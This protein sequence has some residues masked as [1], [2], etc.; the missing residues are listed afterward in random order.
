MQRIAKRIAES[1]AASRREAEKLIEQG[2]VTVDGQLVLS[3]VFFVEDSQVVSIDGK[4]IGREENLLIWKMNK[5]RGYLTTKRDPQSRKTVFELLPKIP[6]RMIYIGRL[7]FNSEG[8]LLFTNSG[9]FARYL[10]LPSTGVRRKYKV[11]FHGS[12]TEE[13]IRAL[14]KG[15]T[16][17]GFRYGPIDVKLERAVGSNSWAIFTLNEGKNR[18]IRKVLEYFHCEVTRL[19][20]ISYGSISLGEL[21]LGEVQ[22]LSPGELKSFV[23]NTKFSDSGTLQ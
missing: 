5:P 20:R 18:E 22:E 21:K 12:L 14:R 15:V 4:A 3:P 6:H 17:D 1:G 7:D 10:E 19:I 9:K 8:L 13:N 11:R 23:K 16:I 2:R